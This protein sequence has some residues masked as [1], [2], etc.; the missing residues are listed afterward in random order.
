MRIRWR[1]RRRG[2]CSSAWTATNSVSRRRR[3]RRRPARLLGGDE[4]HALDLDAVDRRA[5]L[6]AAARLGRNVG[7]ALEDI[8]ARDQRAEGGVLLVEE[9]RVAVHDEELAAGGIGMRG[10]RRGDDALHVR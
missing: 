3:N 7:D 8:L 4:F 5:L 10:A 1:R 9:A 2:G 6:A